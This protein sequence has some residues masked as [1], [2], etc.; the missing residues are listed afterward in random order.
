MDKVV[1]VA[2]AA[3]SGGCHGRG[4]D[5]QRFPQEPAIGKAGTTAKVVT[6]YAVT[7]G[8]NDRYLIGFFQYPRDTWA[9]TRK[10]P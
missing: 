9:G 2:L 7:T 3:L 4:A 10:S 8:E 6:E 5:L 1:P